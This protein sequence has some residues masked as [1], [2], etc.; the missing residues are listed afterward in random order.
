MS[1]IAFLSEK[2]RARAIEIATLVAS[3]VIEYYAGDRPQLD[4][5]Q[6]SPPAVG[7]LAGGLLGAVLLVAELRSITGDAKWSPDDVFAKAFDNAYP[8]GSGLFT[9]WTGVLA[10]LQCTKTRNFGRL[11]QRIRSRLRESLP[12]LLRMTSW[13]RQIT[14]D[15]ISGIS[16]IRIGLENEPETEDLCAA[17]D[18]ELVRLVKAL[19][20]PA[21][22]SHTY[23][24]N[25]GFA[26]GAPGVLLALTLGS[27]DESVEAARS[28]GDFVVAHAIYGQDRLTWPWTSEGASPARMA[29]CYGN[30]GVALSLWALFKRTDLKVYEEAA[31]EALN[32]LVG[33][34]VDKMGIVDE[35]ICHGHVGNALILAG[36]S[37]A[38]GSSDGESRALYHFT[39]SI[40]AFENDLAFGYLQ[41]LGGHMKS[42][43]G[44]LEGSTGIALGLLALSN[45]TNPGWLRFF[46]IPCAMNSSV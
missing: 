46:G 36:L 31:T 23:G 20:A 21:T 9:G 10:V 3:R 45:D 16:G 8:E 35:A 12:E 14:F 32:G 4:G 2:E 6:A 38:L 42:S 22:S 18:S 43:P 28:V 29:W 33:A 15:F 37:H 17:I 1:I 27:A 40:N 34:P 13:D 30:P 19:P 44:L 39:A 11:R 25:L 26:H 5:S 7:H 41:S 24:I